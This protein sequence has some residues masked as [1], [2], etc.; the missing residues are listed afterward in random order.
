MVASYYVYPREVADELLRWSMEIAPQMA[1]ELEVAILG[2]NPRQRD[3]TPAAGETALSINA[4]AMTDDEGEAREMLAILETCPVL[5]RATVRETGFGATLDDLYTGAEATEPEGYRWAVDN[6]WT[7]AGPDELLP[8][9]RELFETVP[10]PISHIFWYPWHEQPLPDAALSVQGKLYIAAFAGWTDERE[11]ESHVRWPTE[12][13]RRLEPLS[14]GIQLADENLGQ[15]R[16]R[17]LSAENED[18]LED[19]RAKHD[20]DGLF[21]SYLMAPA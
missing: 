10:N 2:T 15:R 13:M 12:Q 14:K 16:S 9:V 20:P 18:R 19:L 11:D 3:G 4:V 17:Y 6:M 21:D 5:G 7:D 1:P 8:E